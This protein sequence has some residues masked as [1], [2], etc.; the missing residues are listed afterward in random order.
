MLEKLSFIEKKYKELSQK[1]IDPE[2]INNIEEWQRLVK[3][4]ADI[5]PIVIKYKEYTRAQ[6][7]LEEDKEMLKEKLD[8]EMKELLKEEVAEYEELIE[9][10]EEELRILLIPKDPND[11]KNVIVE[12]RAG[13]G[14]DE[15][16]LFAGDLFRMYSMYAERQ[17]WKTELMSSNEQGVGGFKEVIFMIKGKG[18]YSRLKYESGVHRVQRVPTT[19]SS[20]RIHTSTATVAVLPEAEDIDIEIN[21]NDIRI[22]VFRSSGNGGQSV[23]TTDSAVRITHIPTGMVVSCQ[24]EKSQHK[25]RDKA[26]KILKTRLYDQMMREQHNEIAEERRSQVGTGD[27]SERIRTYNFPQGRITDHRINMTL[28]KLENFL[29]GD[30]DEM[31]D[32][33]ITSDQA[34]KLKQVG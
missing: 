27:R 10:L 14:G 29:D 19:E 7:T 31:I 21:Q 5:E 18:A 1:I 16:G 34:E 15:A 11:H 20:G 28:Y 32:G 30:I 12:I 25:N 9:N 17:G 22:D 6:K 2:I 4:H 26:M 3:E 13:A 8:D 24:D 33:L 23:N